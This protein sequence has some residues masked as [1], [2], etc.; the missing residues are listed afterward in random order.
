MEDL[1]L[2]GG[3]GQEEGSQLALGHL[4]EG[5]VV[6][7]R[8][9]AG[10]RC[11]QAWRR[12]WPDVE[13]VEGFDAEGL[14]GICLEWQ[15]Y[16][17]QYTIETFEGVTCVVPADC[18][19]EYSPPLPE[20][21]GFD[22]AW[23]EAGH[24]D[25]GVLAAELLAQK[26]YCV[27]QLSL[28]AELIRAISEQ[29]QDLQDFALLRCE[30][31]LDYMGRDNCTWLRACPPDAD[32]EAPPKDALQFADRLLTGL[33]TS[34]CEAALELEGRAP[35]FARMGS[36]VEPEPF[37]LMELD[38]GGAE[39]FFDFVKSRK[40]C[41]IL[42]LSSASAKVELYPQLGHCIG[43]DVVKCSLSRGQVLFFRHDIMSYSYQPRGEH[44]ALQTWLVGGMNSLEVQRLDGTQA[45]YAEMLDLTGPWQ[46]EGEQAHIK[47]LMVRMPGR[48]WGYLNFWNMFVAGTD[49][50]QEWNG[51]RWDKDLYY[52][53]DR[54]TA[55]M[56]QRS[57][58]HH[59]GF[60]D[61]TE[62]NAFDNEF[63]CIS[64]EETNCMYPG[65]R[66]VLE[67]G[68]EA[69]WRA[70]Y[71]K[72]CCSGEDIGVHLGDVGPDWHTVV[73]VWHS[74]SVG[75]NSKLKEEGVS[76]C[77][78]SGRLSHVLGLVG[79]INSVATACSSSL[80][81]LNIAHH[82]M[83]NTRDQVRAAGKTMVERHLVMGINTLMGP[84]SF[85]GQCITGGTTFKGRCFTFD[86]GADGYQ[87]GEGCSATFVQ[88]R[89][90]ERADADR[91]G[92]VIGS[93]VNQD[94]RSASLTAPNGP[95]QTALLKSA[96]RIAGLSVQE[97]TCCE[98]HGTGTAL[99]D[100]IEIGALQAALSKR[101]RPV[102][103]TSAKS[104]LS[105]LEASAGMAG[106]AKCI[107]MV[108]MS[109]T[110]PNQHL[111]ALNPHL[112]V[113][114]YPVHFGTEIVPFGQNS[115]YCGVSS[116]GMGGTNARGEVLGRCQR[117][118]ESTSR[119]LT[120]VAI[121]KVDFLC[122]PCPRCLGPMHWLDSAAVP[123]PANS[124]AKYRASLIREELADYS[125]C[126][127]CY[128]GTFRAGDEL[129][130]VANPDYG[131]FIR[132]SWDAFREMQEMQ[133]SVLGEYS[134][135]VVL[136]ETRCERFQ[137]WLEKDK[138]M[139]IYP[140]R[141]EA[142][143]HVRVQGP[144]G[145]DSGNHWLL[146]GRDEQIPAGTVY[147]IVFEWSTRAK[148]VSWAPVKESLDELPRLIGGRGV[149]HRY[150]VVGS[151]ASWAPLDLK[152]LPRSSA[153]EGAPLE[154]EMAFSIGPGGSERF[155]LVRDRDPGQLIYPSPSL[156][157]A[158]RMSGP[159]THGKNRYWTVAGRE[160]ERVSV[161]F[162]IKDAQMMLTMRSGSIGY[163]T[164]ESAR[165]WSRRSFFLVGPFNSWSLTDEL[166]HRKDAPGTFALRVKLEQWSLEFQIVQDGDA[167]RKMYPQARRAA[168][169]TGFL[170]RTEESQA[171]GG[172]P[173]EEDR[174]WL[175]Q[176]M[177]GSVFE[178]VLDL[179]ELDRR[180][181]VTWTQV[182]FEPCSTDA[183]DW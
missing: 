26:G 103:K 2:K 173:P 108:L 134:F 143:Q 114:G 177:P 96:M 36:A 168:S 47:A 164:W 75:T 167:R 105:H 149:E 16:S 128:R 85:I 1:G 8:G 7:V 65:Q 83:L 19:E 56:T 23:P 6:E 37:S 175:I 148:K 160:A 166:E 115:G 46:P 24:P 10:R 43:E 183:L 99:G 42:S 132:G 98:C 91:L 87:R 156:D 45:G 11:I 73:P 161:Q 31:E 123:K 15:P 162:C 68:Y 53:P 155:Q 32:V 39:D 179:K 133:E 62:F 131:V 13:E 150:S 3:V 121:E 58:M 29:T 76:A 67:T 136:G 40:V 159:D 111:S 35:C 12:V 127:A 119:G 57:Y 116:F 97:V 109:A 101:D 153:A 28:S 154:F 165:G 100:P 88:M 138:E 107:M 118:S 33:G 34:L 17:E 4:L 21:G 69:L 106:F 22:L 84:V 93:Y 64:E 50:V 5:L 20:D 77:V 174:Y 52:E 147:R 178:V 145:D 125:V 146:D 86:G 182:D 141:N 170:E 61:E 139:A 113:E 81:A 140:C 59:G 66:I 151:W 180:Q 117:G 144:D 122:L 172:I 95:A 55:M 137:I 130:E 163:Q 78:T 135:C 27:A 70:G 30:T 9:L 120:S 51:I 124:E 94:G 157:D 25:F 181:M 142:G 82:G 171:G 126:S 169:G 60:L 176:G 110:P 112:M 44:L 41:M 48:A 18:V 63:F 79:P 90:S 92:C 158:F 104:N 152:A 74:M 49:C 129:R 80:V 71:T 102:L 72:E 14:R 54:E 89:S 38:R